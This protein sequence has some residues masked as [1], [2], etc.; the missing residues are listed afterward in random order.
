MTDQLRKGFHCSCSQC[1]N[2]YSVDD[3]IK[4]EKLFVCFTC[5]PIFIQKIREGVEIIPKGRS[6]LWKIYFFI[7]LALQL[8]GFISSTQ[9]LLDAKDVIETLIYFIIYPWVI[10]AV[11][12]YSFNRKFLK[13]R[14][15]QVLFPTALVTDIIFFSILFIE[16]NILAHIIP[17]IM[18]MLTL[19]PLIIFQY[20]A[21]YRY[22]YSKTE[23][24]L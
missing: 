7:F 1:G 11:Y 3:M 10:V 8:F 12:G 24:W 15:W 4:I 6:K 5:K 13:R 21:L 2:T 16:Q 19:F 22:G 14:V 20:I 17:L 18:V 23:P 9:N